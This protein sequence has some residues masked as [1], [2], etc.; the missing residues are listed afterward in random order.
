MTGGDGVIA[1][2]NLRG[3]VNPALS[4]SGPT[5]SVSATDTDPAAYRVTQRALVGR[6]SDAGRDAGQAILW[7]NATPAKAPT[8]DV[9]QSTMAAGTQRQTTMT[10]R[11]L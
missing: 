3:P 7:R 2:Q 11:V 1:A 4:L 5:P 6:P 10:G 8:P 9:F